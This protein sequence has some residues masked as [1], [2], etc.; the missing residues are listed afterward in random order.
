MEEDEKRTLIT[1]LLRELA[2]GEAAK[3]IPE[4]G[5]VAFATLY[6]QTGA[7]YNVTTRHN[8]AWQAL[9]ELVRTVRVAGL[10]LNMTTSKADHL[11]AASAPAIPTPQRIAL[12]EGNKTMAT[13]LHAADVALPPSRK[14]ANVPYQAIQATTVKVLPQPDG[15][16][17]IE[18][19]GDGRKYPDVKV[20]KW[21]VEAAAGL[22]KHVTAEPMDKAGEYK[23]PC[24]VYYTEGNEYTKPDNTQAHY[25]DVEHVRPA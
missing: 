21:K 18:F 20:N 14:G 3:N 9:E 17:T 23:L 7:A 5:G 25:K 16:T 6:S 15:K 4:A 10:V 19:Y 13:E 1:D 22:M 11:P 2:E 24:V 12:E 8:T